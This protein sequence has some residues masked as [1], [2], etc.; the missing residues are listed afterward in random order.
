MRII[1]RKLNSVSHELKII[2]ADNSDDI[3]VLETGTY[4]L[5]DICHFFVEKELKTIYGFWGMLSQGYKIAQLSG[6]TNPL[7]EKLRLIECIVGTVQSVYS[8]HM[9]YSDA[10]SYLETVDWDLSVD[11]L[12][13][14]VI[15]QIRGFM[16]RW[17]HLPIGVEICLE[18]KL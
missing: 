6:K 11:P 4:Q 10:Y 2:R 15:P 8:A 13:D 3:A 18:F 12:L 5:H 9:N 1:F 7:T 16:E 14:N 17:K